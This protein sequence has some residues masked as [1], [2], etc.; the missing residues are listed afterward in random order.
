MARPPVLLVALTGLVLLLGHGATGQERYVTDTRLLAASLPP[1]WCCSTGYIHEPVIS[2]DRCQAC[3]PHVVRMHDGW[4]V[5]CLAGRAP[6]LAW[7]TPSRA[8]G[9]LLL[10]VAPPPPARE[11]R[12]A[13]PTE[14]W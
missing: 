10:R 3:G 8:A 13:P 5:G 9:R 14:S 1:G 4:A 7:L 6:W 12:P 11:G 2:M